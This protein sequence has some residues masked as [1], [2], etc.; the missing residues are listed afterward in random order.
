MVDAAAANLS[1]MSGHVFDDAAEKN[2]AQDIIETSPLCP[3]IVC[4]SSPPNRIITEADKRGGFLD[5]EGS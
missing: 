3:P 1:W 4:N 5:S 2:I